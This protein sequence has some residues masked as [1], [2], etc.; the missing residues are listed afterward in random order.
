MSSRLRPLFVALTTSAVVVVAFFGV[1]YLSAPKLEL[2]PPK[3]APDFALS[4]RLDGKAGPIR[5]SDHHGQPVILS[6]WASW[7]DACKEEQAILKELRGRPGE[8]I[9]IA[10]GDEQPAALGTALKRADD[11]SHGFDEGNRL[12]ELYQLTGVPTTILV[13]SRG[14]L[15][16]RWNRQLR[17]TDLPVLIRHLEGKPLN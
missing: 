15:I 12:A 11:F 16:H 4:Q 6:F 17:A 9:S 10:T 7:C 2:A 5:L 13:D 14:Q 8:R 3:P 1:Q